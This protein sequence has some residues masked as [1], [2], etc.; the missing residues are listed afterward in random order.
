[1]VTP[2]MT[3]SRNQICVFIVAASF[4]ERVGLMTCRQYTH[5]YC[6]YSAVQPV[7]KRGTHRTRLAQ[8]LHGLQRHLCAPEKDLSSGVLH[9]SRPWLL[10]HLPC[11]TITSSSSFTLPSTTTPEHA[12]QSGQRDLLQEHNLCKHAR[13]KSIANKKNHPGVKTLQSDGN[14]RK[15]ISTGACEQ[16]ACDQRDCDCLEDLEDNRSISLV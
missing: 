9:M 11:T 13:S 14:L 2:S 5:K 1:M 12:L 3:E 15:T 10:P 8:E 6:T 16:R 4:L 7:H